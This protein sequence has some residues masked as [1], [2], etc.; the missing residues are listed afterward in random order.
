MTV[1]APHATVFR[2]LCQLRVAP[3]SYDIIDNG[4]RRS[5]RELTPGLEDLAVGQEV[6]SIFTLADFGPERHLTLRISKPSAQRL[7]GD[8]AC[9]YAVEPGGVS[10]ETRLVVKLVVSHSAKPTLAGRIMRRFCPG[11]IGS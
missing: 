9:T 7:F 4:G 1:Q 6:M 8:L 2:W 5:P 11:A 3:Y 10:N